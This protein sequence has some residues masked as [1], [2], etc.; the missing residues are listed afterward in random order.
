MFILG[1]ITGILL[2]A[3]SV[4]IGYLYRPA[5]AIVRAVD[6]HK[7]KRGSLLPFNEDQT[8]QDDFLKKNSD[9]DIPIG[10]LF[11]L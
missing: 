11:P 4:A 6:E 8:I 10:E 3:L 1:I 7:P 2:S 9:R 5:D